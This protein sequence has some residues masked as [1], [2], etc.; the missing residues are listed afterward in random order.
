MLDV[1]LVKLNYES[2]LSVD[3]EFDL[4]TAYLAAALRRLCGRD[5]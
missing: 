2:V 3:R 1:L 5:Y 4:G